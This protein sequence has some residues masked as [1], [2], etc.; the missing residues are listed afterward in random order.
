MQ[1][2]SPYGDHLRVFPRIN[3][4]SYRHLINQRI[5]IKMETDLFFVKVKMGFIFHQ[6]DLGQ[7]IAL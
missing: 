5:S 3:R 4:Q 6:E 7:M 1:P 2:F